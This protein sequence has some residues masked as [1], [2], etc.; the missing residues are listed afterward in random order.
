MFASFISGILKDVLSIMK[1]RMPALDAILSAQLCGEVI[2]DGQSYIYAPD[3]DGDGIVCSECIEA[4]S[5]AEILE[6]CG[7]SSVTEVISV[8]AGKVMKAGDRY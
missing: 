5:V 8:L 4:F 6:V 7:I 2:S 1:R 3:G